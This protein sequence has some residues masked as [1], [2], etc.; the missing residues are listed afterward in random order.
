MS[1]FKGMI[2]MGNKDVFPPLNRGDTLTSAAM[3]EM[4]RD[5]RDALIY[6]M[7][8]SAPKVMKWGPKDKIAM[9]MGWIEGHRI[10]FDF[11]ECYVT[12]SKAIVFIVN[13]AQHLTIEDDPGLFP[14]D[15][16]ITQLRLIIG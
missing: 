7:S 12:D 14:S 5:M 15:S 6:G 1:I 3:S 13:K 4:E 16:L 9:R 11:L 8:A 10:P 2:G